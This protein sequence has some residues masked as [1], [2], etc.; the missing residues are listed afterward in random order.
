[1]KNGGSTEQLGDS[2]DSYKIQLGKYHKLLLLELKHDQNKQN[3]LISEK[4]LRDHKTKLY[5]ALDEEA[6]PED[7]L[8]EIFLSLRVNALQ[9]PPDQRRSFVEL[10]IKIDIFSVTS[11]K[12]FD[13][14]NKLLAMNNHGLKHALSAMISVLV[15]TAQGV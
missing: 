15:S 1:M 13:V 6:K 14:L 5:Q 11:Q 12:G 4:V 2:I 10:L 7:T 8:T 9:V 3:Y